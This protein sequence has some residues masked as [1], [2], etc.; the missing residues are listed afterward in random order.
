MLNKVVTLIVNKF[1]N[2]V[3]CGKARPELT[4]MLINTTGKI[5]SYS[6]I[7]Y[8]VVVEINKLTNTVKPEKNSPSGIK[9]SK[10]KVGITDI[11]MT[12]ESG[13]TVFFRKSFTG[14]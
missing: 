3:F 14:S 10:P 1:V 5:I 9:K 2:I 6:H 11:K 8:I 4:F 7:K 12:P 13:K